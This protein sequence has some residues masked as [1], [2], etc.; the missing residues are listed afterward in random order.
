MEKK[1]YS[2]VGVDGNAFCIMAYVNMAMREC[3]KSP[4]ERNAYMH[5]V[6]KG[7]YNNLVATSLEIIEQLNAQA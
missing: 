6:M 3:G 2:L 5:G 1:T 7:D 4:K